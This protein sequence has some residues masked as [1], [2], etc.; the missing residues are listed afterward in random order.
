VPI[1]ANLSPLRLKNK[2]FLLLKASPMNLSDVHLVERPE[3]RNVLEMMVVALATAAHARCILQPVDDVEKKLKFRF[4][5]G[6][7][8]RY[9]VGIATPSPNN[10]NKNKRRHGPEKIRPM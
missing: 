9:T 7:I 8:N 5:L 2:S 3:E 4:S 10:T 1:V 6:A